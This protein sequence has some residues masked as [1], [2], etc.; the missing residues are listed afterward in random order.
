MKK[1]NSLLSFVAVASFLCGCGNEINDN[2]DNSINIVTSISSE[3]IARSP[4]LDETGKGNFMN[5]DIF[6]LA[7]SNSEKE[8]VLKDFI[9]GTS[10]FKWSDLN[11]SSGNGKVAFLACYPKQNIKDGKFTFDLATVDEKDLLLAKVEGVAINAAEP[12]YLNFR[13]AMH[14]LDIY[15]NLEEDINVTTRCEALSTCEVNMFENTV[16][17]QNGK[18]TVFTQSGKNISFLIVPQQTVDVTLNI[19]YGN[20]TKSYVLNE[21]IKD[22]NQLESGKKMELTLNVKNGDIQIENP[23][24]GDWDNQGSVDGSI[25]M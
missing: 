8:Y 13:H 9:V 24:I 11:I 10:D 7:V 19:T 22:Y 17:A 21:I 20:K 16:T 15:Y 18:K 5:G 1:I 12:V 4:V 14:K 3:D 2:T 6:S 23:T 25:I